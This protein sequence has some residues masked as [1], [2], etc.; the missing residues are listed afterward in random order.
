MENVVVTK[1]DV[2]YSAI[3]SIVSA[4]HLHESLRKARQ[5]YARIQSVLDGSQITC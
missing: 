3:A 5:T 2:P 1:S 4:G